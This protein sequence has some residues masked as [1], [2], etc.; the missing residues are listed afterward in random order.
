MQDRPAAAE[1]VTAVAGLLQDTILPQSTGRTAFEIRVAVNALELVA[2]QLAHAEESHAAELRRLETLIGHAGSLME[3]NRKLCTRIASG[4]IDA[5]D[6]ALIDHLWQTTL[7]K[8][9]VDQPSYAAFRDEL[10]R[11]T[12][13]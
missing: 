1:L 9:S 2:R 10:Q 5:D 8:L 6:A 12:R 7:E 3:L 4:V 11:Q 13:G